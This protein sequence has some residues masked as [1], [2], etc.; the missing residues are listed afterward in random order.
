MPV[1]GPTN[2]D[3][4]VVLLT[5]TTTFCRHCKYHMMIIGALCGFWGRL[6]LHFGGLSAAVFVDNCQPKAG[7]RV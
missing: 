6:K 7:L 5:P 1:T 2:P 3:N 4:K